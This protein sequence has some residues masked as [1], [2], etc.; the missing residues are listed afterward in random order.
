MNQ[1]RTGE[2]KGVIFVLRYLNAISIDQGFDVEILVSIQNRSKRR[3]LIEVFDQQRQTVSG[4]LTLLLERSEEQVK[5]LANHIFILLAVFGG[6]KDRHASQKVA[7]GVSPQPLI[8]PLSEREIEVLQLIAKGLTNQ[9]IANKLYLSL[10]TVKVHTRNIY[11]KLGVHHRTEAV[12]KARM[13]GLL[14][15]T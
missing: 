2:L 14:S 9:E 12:A 3:I 4:E 11:G 1:R 8:E 5:S 15:S 10:N 6:K 13:L 7:H